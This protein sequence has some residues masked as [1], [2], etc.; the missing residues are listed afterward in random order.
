MLSTLTLLQSIV[1][2]SE[3]SVLKFKQKVKVGNPF[4]T[5][6]SWSKTNVQ[7]LPAP[8]CDKNKCK[9]PDCFCSG[10]DIPGGLPVEQVPQ[11]VTLTFQYGI[12]LSTYLSYSSIIGG[13]TNP[14]KC[15][16]SGTFFVSHQY[17]D[18]GLV[19]DLYAARQEIGVNAITSS[20]LK[21]ATEKDWENE[22]GG[23]S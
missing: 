10:F 9:L 4:R 22:M 15:P 12:T 18:Y 5:Q 7:C 14:N 11:M 6:E 3:T 21:D 8:S 17:T 1:V 16:V 20:D 23:E 2:P 13:R 19:H